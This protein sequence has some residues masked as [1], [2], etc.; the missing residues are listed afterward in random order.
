MLYAGYSSIR[1]NNDVDEPE[2][3]THLINN[4][5]EHNSKTL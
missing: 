3:I 5:N 2:W 4:T 1:R